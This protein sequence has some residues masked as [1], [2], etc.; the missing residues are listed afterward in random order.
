MGLGKCSFLD[1]VLS[2]TWL[3]FCLAIGKSFLAVGSS[4]GRIDVIEIAQFL[5]SV[6]TSS[7]FSTDYVVELSHSVHDQIP[8]YA[9]GCGITGMTWI[10]MHGKNVT[11]FFL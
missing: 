9:D 4:D 3:I 11:V 7:G 8:A 2:W 1:T 5:R 10:E 6:P